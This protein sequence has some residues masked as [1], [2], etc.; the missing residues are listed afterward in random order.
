MGTKFSS[1]LNQ[2]W[3]PFVNVDSMFDARWAG[4]PKNVKVG[5]RVK[6]GVFQKVIPFLHKIVFFS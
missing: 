4:P 3:Q 2:H 5:G 6:G 1:T